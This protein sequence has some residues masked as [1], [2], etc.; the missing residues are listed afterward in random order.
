MPS[1]PLALREAA[2]LWRA[3]VGRNS[4]QGP[5]PARSRESEQEEGAAPVRASDEAAVPAA[6][7]I[8]RDLGAEAPRPLTR[9]DCEMI[10]VRCFRPL[11]LGAVCY[12]TTGS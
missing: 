4:P 7:S 5:G 12:A 6:S 10:N 2:A 8:R 11:R 1:R 3:C 9:R